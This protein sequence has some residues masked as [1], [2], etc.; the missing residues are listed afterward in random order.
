MPLQF[1]M[2]MEIEP[3]TQVK[4]I[5]D[6]QHGAVADY[7]TIEIEDADSDAKLMNQIVDKLE[8]M[9]PDRRILIEGYEGFR[10]ITNFQHFGAAYGDIQMYKDAY[11]TGRAPAHFNPPF[12]HIMR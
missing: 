5:F 4:H 9:Y 10:Y 11:S 7:F 6:I 8:A 3:M 1:M 2:L 12:F